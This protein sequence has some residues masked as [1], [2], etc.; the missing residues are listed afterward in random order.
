MQGIFLFNVTLLLLTKLS[1]AE[2]S[3][4]CPQSSTLKGGEP[5]KQ[6]EEYCEIFKATSSWEGQSVRVGPY[7][8]W[9]K[10]GKKKLWVSQDG[11]LT[12]WTAK[13]TI[14]SQGK[15]VDYKLQGKWL[16]MDKKVTAT[17]SFEK[18]KPLGTWIFSL[19]DHPIR[20]NVIFEPEKE[21]VT[22]KAFDGTTLV[23]EGDYI[24]RQPIGLWKIYG[25]DGKIQYEGSVPNAE[26]ASRHGFELNVLSLYPRM[27]SIWSAPIIRIEGRWPQSKQI[28]FEQ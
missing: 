6:F 15:F 18:G 21:L 12:E 8:S 27:T 14:A 22:W 25:S 9:F 24:K 4:N 11:D 10:N 28:S 13:G 23:S 5:P 26:F 2:A 1:A 16:I 20:F 17:G 3:L 7:K 19:A